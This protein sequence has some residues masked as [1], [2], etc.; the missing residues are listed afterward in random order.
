M[1]Y[2]RAF[3]LVSGFGIAA[4]TAGCG[5][6]QPNTASQM[7]PPQGV[8]ASG[9]VSP[10]ADSSGASANSIGTPAA[11]SAGTPAAGTPAVS[12]A[13]LPGS[14]VASPV[15]A[16]SPIVTGGPVVTGG[17]A[18][19]TPAAASTAAAPTSAAV[20]AAAPAVNGAVDSPAASA[21]AVASGN[22][23]GLPTAINQWRAQGGNLAGV[24]RVD[25]KPVL[26]GYS[27]MVNLLPYLGHKEL[28]GKFDFAK[29][30]HDVANLPQVCQV[31]PAFI[32]PANPNVQ[33]KVVGVKNAVGPA[34]THFVGMSGVEDSRNLVAA[35]LPRTDPRAGIFG[36]DQIARP[37]EITDGG[38]NTIMIVAA[39]KIVGPWASGGGATI[40]GA[41]APYF[42]AITGFG[43]V[44]APGA[45]A[46]VAMA[47]GSVKQISKD[48]DP[49]VFRALCTTHGA[50]T[51]DLSA[52]GNA[53]RPQ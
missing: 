38:S 31:V 1:S 42:D 35:A 43:S 16:S 10:V 25:D 48:I 34:F 49:A 20:G 14:S 2:L 19:A 45:G 27:W 23:V 7:P 8:V 51:I 39:G 18:V 12:G 5:K 44:G 22:T 17:P 3:V 50:E 13:A 15:V 33:M 28:Y 11:G 26:A 24:K 53:S 21:N 37:E 40:R 47:D 46:V 30:W 4:I 32:D 41:R 9:A 29:G 36:Y 6:S 52:I